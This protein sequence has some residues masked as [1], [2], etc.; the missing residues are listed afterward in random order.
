MSYI[1]VSR[2]LFYEFIKKGMPACLISNRW[3]AHIDNLDNYFK[4]ITF[5]RE[6]NIPEDAE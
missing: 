4:K 6:K 2:P 5:P 1:G 3:Y